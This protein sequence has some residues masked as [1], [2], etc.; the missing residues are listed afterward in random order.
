VRKALANLTGV[1]ED[2][3]LI[4]A[5]GQASADIADARQ[6]CDRLIAVLEPCLAR[7]HRLRGWLG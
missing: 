1:L 5:E 4:A 3:S 6:T 2:A 7:L